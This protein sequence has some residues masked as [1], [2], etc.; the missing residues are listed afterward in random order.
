MLSHC[1]RFI[2]LNIPLVL[3]LLLLILLLTMIHSVDGEVRG[4]AEAVNRWCSV[5]LVMSRQTR[6]VNVM[7]W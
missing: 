2:Q 4:C 7:S 6:G 3:L 1:V 5:V